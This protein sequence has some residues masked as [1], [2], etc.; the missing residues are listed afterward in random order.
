MSTKTI[1][2]ITSNGNGDSSTPESLILNRDEDGN[3]E[4]IDYAV[5][6]TLYIVRD[7]NGDIESYHNNLYNWVINKVDGIITGITVENL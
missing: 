3:I 1:Q 2:I 5:S 7:E 6:P 4:S